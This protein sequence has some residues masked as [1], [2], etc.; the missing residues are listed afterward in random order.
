MAANGVAQGYSAQPKKSK[1]EKKVEPK[2][3]GG[4]QSFL[5]EERNSISNQEKQQMRDDHI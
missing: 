4:R 2:N 1:E 5:E 3:L